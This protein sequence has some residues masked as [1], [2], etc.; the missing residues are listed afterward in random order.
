MFFEDLRIISGVISTLNF[1]ISFLV[2]LL[3]YIEFRKNVRGGLLVFWYLIY[4]VVLGESPI[5]DSSYY[6][7]FMAMVFLLTHFILAYLLHST[8][9]GKLRFFLFGHSALLFTVYFLNVLF[10]KGGMG[11][12]L[13]SFW[14]A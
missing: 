5:V 9:D 12:S 8:L 1:I 7:P 3:A 14:I 6:M 13:L 11:L 10:I 4:S 2:G